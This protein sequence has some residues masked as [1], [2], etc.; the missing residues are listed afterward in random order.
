MRAKLRDVRAGRTLFM[1]QGKGTPGL[2]GYA[3]VSTVHVDTKPFKGS[4]GASW[5][6]RYSQTCAGRKV[7]FRGSLL[8]L[9]VRAD[10]HGSNRFHYNCNRM[11]TRRASAEAYASRLRHGHVTWL[12]VPEPDP[13]DEL[14]Y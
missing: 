1:V 7:G 8:D 3:N 10:Y 2:P 5:W 9:G 13:M 11:F 6:F 14:G 4:H 12:E